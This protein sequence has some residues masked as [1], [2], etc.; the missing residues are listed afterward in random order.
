MSYSHRRKLQYKDGSYP[1]FTTPQPG[2]VV[3]HIMASL[4]P[5]ISAFLAQRGLPPTQSWLDDFL[6]TA[7]ANAPLPALQQTALFRILATDLTTSIQP[8]ST[9]TLAPGLLNVNA[10]EQNL[11]G[12]I[13]LQVLHIED[14]GRSAWSQVENL[15]AQERGETTKGREIIRNIP[16]DAAENSNLPDPTAADRS[17]GPHKLVLQDCKGLNIYA[18]ELDKL[19]GLNVRSLSIGAKL[20][21]KN[22]VVARGVLM[23]RPACVDLL[24]G[25]VDVWDKAWRA[26]RKDALRARAGAPAR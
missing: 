14:V 16:G 25:K 12:P 11:A 6:S 5:S 9:N 26:A 7:R 17:V 15:E 24:G 23:L 21:L 1:H 20:L 22:A 3:G 13:V 18:F 19:D 10:Q 8:S 4:G 2:H